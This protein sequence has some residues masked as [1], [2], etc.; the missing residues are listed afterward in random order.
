MYFL[1]LTDSKPP[2][3]PQPRGSSVAV[4]IPGALRQSEDLLL[5]RIV[6]RHTSP[7]GLPWQYVNM[8]YT[9]WHYHKVVSIYAGLETTDNF[10]VMNN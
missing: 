2:R 6:R 10:N 5:A 1:T 8:I 7:H 9:I 4:E 3:H